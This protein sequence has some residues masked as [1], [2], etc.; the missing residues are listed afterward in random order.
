MRLLILALAFSPAI[1]SAQATDQFDGR[2]IVA[3]QY[4]PAGVL[5][6]DDLAKAQVIKVG[7]PLRAENVAEAIDRLFATGEFDDIRAEVQP[8]GD[9]LILR[10]VTT[11][12]R[13]IGAVAIQGKIVDPPNRGEL[14]SLSQLRRGNEFEEQ[15]LHEAVDRMKRLLVAN[16]FYDA[17][18]EP[19]IKTD[20]NR[21]VFLTFDIEHG[22]RAKYEMPIVTGETKLPVETIVSATGWRVR[23]VHLWRQVT[24]A[25][26]QQAPAKV[27][28][29]YQSKD[30]LKAEVRVEKL[31]YDAQARRVQP[32]L[33]VVPGPIVTIT[34]TG[35]KLSRRALKR[36]VPVF[37]ER[38]VDNDLLSEGARNLR[39]YL[40]SK[41]YYDATV[42]FRTS[43][44]DEDHLSIEYAISLGSRFK[45]VHIEIAGNTYFDEETLR[46][47]MFIEPATFYLRRGRFSRAFLRRDEDN[48]TNLYRANGFRD[49]KITSETFE[50][51]RGKSEQVGIAIH[52]EEG[53]QWVV[54]S[55]TLEGVS[56]AEREALEPQLSSGA[57]Q[58][59]SEVSLA[60]D[61]NMALTY[62][63]SQGYPN[64]DFKAA[65]APATTLN[66]VTV[67]YTATPGRRE[68]VREILTTGLT[69]TRHSLIT[70]RI[71]LHAGDPISG[72][73][74]RAIQKSLYDMGVFARVDTAI[75]NPDG[76]TN[77]KYVV[78]AFDEANRYT[79]TVGVGAQV[80]R[81]GTPSTTANLA[82]AGGETGF[83]PIFTLNVNRLNFLGI[84]HTVGF[85]GA[86]SSLQRLASVS[87]F[88]P[89]FMNKDGRSITYALVYNE[90]FDVRTFASKREEAS[91]QVAQRVS[92][93]TT[94][95]VRFAY[96]NVGVS[97]V[98]IP[99]LLIPQLLQSVRIG[100]LSFNVI[101]DRR[102]SS[103]D[104]HRGMYNTADVGLSTKYFGSDRSFGR[105]LLRNAAYYR[106]S[107]HVVFARQTQFG[108]IAPF[109]APQGLTAE[110]SVPLP[111]RFFGGG[112]D[113]L[114]AFPYNQA[115]PRDIGAPLS[116]GG[117]SSVPTGFPL[118]GNA[119]VFNTVEVRVPLIGENIGAAVFHDM[120]N[121]YTSLSNVSFR[122]H[123]RDLNDFNYG[124]H[125]IG[126]GLRYKTPIG[127]V[128]GDFAYSIN[129]P[130]YLGF[131]GTP[132]DLLNCGT[133]ANP[134]CVSTRQSV[135]HFQ[136]FFSIGQT[137]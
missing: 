67:V 110:Q 124:V 30:R 69:H 131:S 23:F 7:D 85:R 27:E 121:V 126:T 120:G 119:L 98:V 112:E 8:S 122:F 48:L 4:A 68:F 102:D 50:N 5:H 91:V 9:G 34:A 55:V 38:A 83:S 32:T 97:D 117:P 86:Y 56:D 90:T 82:T 19:T 16:G 72:D 84:G 71:T 88:V 41:G 87:Y 20:D 103:T 57:G 99:V 46:E 77:H 129:P 76:E 54:D 115:G 42:D 132:Q 78:Y 36:Y 65:W 2:R 107:K 113:S 40:Q 125:A 123:Q 105:V 49:V 80:G 3:V 11:P 104:P 94:A 6:Q 29:K 35:A 92:R 66:H 10:F 45:L 28:A 95:F 134:T 60:A 53:P 15:D 37:Q 130:A 22:K 81:F 137:F 26:T 12:V 74:Q 1:I 101:Q 43:D 73:T 58:P 39:D 47:R 89:R 63:S 106:L 75:E 59:F 100:M 116:P 118:G 24:Q 136:F 61:R 51:Y 33:A 109:A 96:R 111:E 93:S 70:E 79:V 133:I 128:R 31:D 13:Y 64:A 14:T 62:Y 135:S 17:T 108:V 114:R 52:V 18:V 21:Q 127:P 44:P 25:R